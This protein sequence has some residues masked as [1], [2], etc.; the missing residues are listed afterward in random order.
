M[1]FFQ[2]NN[3]SFLVVFL[4]RACHTS[5]VNRELI[6]ALKTIKCKVFIAPEPQTSEARA[7]FSGYAMF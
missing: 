6:I 1:R 7:R 5:V 3:Y 2:R 4:S